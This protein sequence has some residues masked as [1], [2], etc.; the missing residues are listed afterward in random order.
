[1][2]S[3]YVAVLGMANLIQGTAELGTLYR[4]RHTTVPEPPLPGAD[5]SLVLLNPGGGT[6]AS[7]SFTPYA[8][9]EAVAASAAAS[10]MNAI[11]GL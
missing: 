1:M 9:T 7:H 8:D 10:H 11:K 2:A 3:E 4:L 6:L 5:W